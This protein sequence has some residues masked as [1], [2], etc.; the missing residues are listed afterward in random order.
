[1]SRFRKS[2]LPALLLGYLGVTPLA[3]HAAPAP[4]FTPATL[5]IVTTDGNS[6][7]TDVRSARQL[8]K[9]IQPCLGKVQCEEISVE[10]CDRCVMT[11]EAVLG[12]YLV[13]SRSGPPGPLYDIIDDRPGR[14]NTATFSLKDLTTIFV[15]YLT[16]RKTIPLA[17]RD[18]GQI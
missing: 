8:K 5:T 11:A 14:Q 13:Q 16:E 3:A 6:R 9:A 1:M 15:D 17:W 4:A 18:T 2:L 7:V 10:T 12:G